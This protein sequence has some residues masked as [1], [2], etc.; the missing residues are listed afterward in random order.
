[1]KGMIKETKENGAKEVGI[2][3][4]LM[5]TL[6]EADMPSSFTYSILHCIQPISPEKSPAI[7]VY[8]RK[9]CVQ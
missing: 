5:E 9:S 3:S 4:R 8:L 6:E 7:L 1:M 2:I